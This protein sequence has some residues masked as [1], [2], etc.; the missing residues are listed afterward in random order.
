[1][2]DKIEIPGH[3]GFRPRFNKVTSMRPEEVVA[4][5][6]DILAEQG[7]PVSGEAMTGHAS[8]ELPADQK[9]LWSP[10]LTITIEEGPEGK[11]S[12]VRGMYSPEPGIWTLFMF[13]YTTI[14]FTIFVLLMWGSSLWALGADA[15]VL[16]WVPILSILFLAIWLF[17]RIGQ[18]L[19]R[20]QIAILHQQ[21]ERALEG[22]NV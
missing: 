21:I 9:Q 1:M 17:A 4:S 16:W 7:C 6:K 22:K 19:S 11:G 13:L 2:T 3:I 5:I 18:R 15:S 20:H 8:I 14:G 12:R 10:R